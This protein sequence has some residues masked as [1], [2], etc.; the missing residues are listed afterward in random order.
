[1]QLMIRDELTVTYPQRK[2]PGTPVLGSVVNV[3]HSHN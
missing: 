3:I 1:M 2:E